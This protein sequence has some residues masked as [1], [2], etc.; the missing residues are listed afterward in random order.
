MST[1]AL[2]HIKDNK[3]TILTIYKHCDGYLSGL[4]KD[5]VDMLD[6]GKSVIVNGNRGNN[7]QAFNTI[8][9]MAAYIVKTLKDGIGGTYIYPPDAKDCGEEYTYTLWA[10]EEES[11]TSFFSET[12][13]KPYIMVKEGNKKVYSGL[14]A[15]FNPN[16]LEEK[17]SK[18]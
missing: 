3:K 18:E 12:P 14:L 1:R 9:C 17:L 11:G 10:N 15:N 2:I 6:N 7:P 13:A 4:G 16:A 5:L 8:G